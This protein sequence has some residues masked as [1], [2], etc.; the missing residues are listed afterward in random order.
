MD[1]FV[2]KRGGTNFPTTR[3][4]SMVNYMPPVGK[5]YTTLIDPKPVNALVFMDE[6]DLLNNPSN[7]INDGNIGLR[8]YPMVEWGDSPGRR[9]GN[10]ATVSM[11]DGHA[12]YWKWKSQRRFFARGG[13]TPDEKP[14]LLKI[15]HGLP[16][17]PQ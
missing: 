10:G 16:G 15:Q 14:D 5:K 4:I 7:G 11:A 3:S 8:A 1:R 13:V 6:D 2:I 9:H 12:E 17:F